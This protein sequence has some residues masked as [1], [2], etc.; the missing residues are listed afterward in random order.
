[1]SGGRWRDKPVLTPEDRVESQSAASENVF[2]V[3]GHPE[4]HMDSPRP[5][6]AAQCALM[7]RGTIHQSGGGHS[8]S[9]YMF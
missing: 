5:G 4:E 2:F 8:A 3:M 9:F 6:V 1:M 7:R